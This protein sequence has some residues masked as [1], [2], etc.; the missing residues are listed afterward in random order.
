MRTPANRAP[1]RG[2]AVLVL[3]S[4]TRSLIAVIRSLGRRGLRDH[5]AG[6]PPSAPALRSRYVD[7]IHDLP[8]YAADGDAWMRALRSVLRRAPFDLGLPCHH[9]AVL[10]LQ[11]DRPRLEAR[12]HPDVPSH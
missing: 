11:L 2:R 7:T 1:G 3:G 12:A 4:D 9:P 10:P 6:A 8:P 5:V